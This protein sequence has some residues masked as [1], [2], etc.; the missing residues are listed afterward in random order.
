V[1]LKNLLQMSDE[2]LVRRIFRDRIVLIGETQPTP[3]ASRRR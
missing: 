3:A 2:A 1:P